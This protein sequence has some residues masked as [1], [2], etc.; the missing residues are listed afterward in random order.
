M[1]LIA[2]LQGGLNSIVKLIAD[3]IRCFPKA[4]FSWK[5]GAETGVSP[6][7]KY[8]EGRRSKL[9]K[10]PLGKFTMPIRK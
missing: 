9:S 4:Y 10:F 1:D 8:L 7:P 2:F 6:P 3:L 5:E